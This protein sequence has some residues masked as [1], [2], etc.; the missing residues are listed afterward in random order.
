MDRRE[1]IRTAGLTAAA[2]AV[3]GLGALATEPRDYLAPVFRWDG[4]LDQEPT[5]IDWWDMVPG[6]ILAFSTEPEKWQA[7]SLP[8]YSK[9]GIEAVWCRAE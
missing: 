9:D 6:D 7:A 3:H 5:R 4:P 8:Y 2:V 1:F